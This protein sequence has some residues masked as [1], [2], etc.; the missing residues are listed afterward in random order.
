MIKTLTSTSVVQAVTTLSDV[1][2]PNAERTSSVLL[3]IYSWY[4][5]CACP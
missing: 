3:L 1:V 2:S 5:T 4:Y